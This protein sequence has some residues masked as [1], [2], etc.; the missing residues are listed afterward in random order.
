L[1]DDGTVWLNLGDCYVANRG[2][3]AAKPGHDNKAV[4]ESL[5]I[6]SYR[7][8]GNGLK[9][10]DLVGIPWSVAFALR[11]DGWYLRSDIIWAK[12]NPMPE[13]VTDRP[14][15][16]HEYLFLLAKSEQ[17]YYDHEAIKEPAVF[18]GRPRGGTNAF[19][20]QGQNRPEG[21]GRANRKGREL[22]AVGGGDCRNK[23]SVW[24]VPTQPYPEAHFAT[25]PEDLINPCI[26]AGCPKGGIVLDPFVGSGTTL[27]V[28][29]R[30]GCKGIGAE[31]NADYIEMAAKRLSQEVFSFE[32]VPA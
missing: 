9:E 4:H 8:G 26:L 24:T 17:Y 29:K 14:T 23:R 25:F 2:N 18:A 30:L 16:A 7:I 15:K 31:L 5:Q 28:A 3:S 11:A 12:P 32:G 6:R 27:L 13:S 10:K 22:A 20:G 21:S 19:C 1:R